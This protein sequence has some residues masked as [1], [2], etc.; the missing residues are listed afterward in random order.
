MRSTGTVILEVAE[1]KE[2]D[3]KGT[4]SQISEIGS[5]ELQANMPG[6]VARTSGQ[7][8]EMPG[9]IILTPLQTMASFPWLQRGRIL[10]S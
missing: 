2:V 3:L 10:F 7:S 6:R 4:I 1:Y 8:L 5:G 9:G